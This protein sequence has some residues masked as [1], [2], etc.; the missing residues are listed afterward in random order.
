MSETRAFQTPGLRLGR[1]PASGLIV[2][3]VRANDVETRTA[4][5]TALGAALPT[6]PA[7]PIA[8]TGLRLYWTAP[9]TVLLDVGQDDVAAWTARLAR[10]LAGRHAAVH[11]L[12]DARTRFVVA[13]SAARGVLAKGTGIDL[14]PRGLPIG[15]AAL[16][17]L[18]QI[19]VLIECTHAEP[20]F[21][22]L[23]ERPLETHLWTWLVDAARS[24]PR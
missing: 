4:A 10:A 19:P 5:A 2:L 20:I 14:D 12:G 6:G 21:A 16:T 18:A 9:D 23:A 15:G 22:I 11:D 3:R 8:A 24:L 17:R 1:A 13:G 7:R